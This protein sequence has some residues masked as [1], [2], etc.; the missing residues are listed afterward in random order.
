MINRKNIHFIVA[1]PHNNYIKIFLSFGKRV[2]C[3]PCKFRNC[4]RKRRLP[5]N[6]C[7]SVRSPF[8]SRIIFSLNLNWR[9]SNHIPVARGGS[10]G[11]VEPP[12]RVTGS[13]ITSGI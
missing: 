3:R 1:Y 6:I 13:N 11:S 12:F 10:R 5:A 9:D 4:L 2:S 7:L 8:T